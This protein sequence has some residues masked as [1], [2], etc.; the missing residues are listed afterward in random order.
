M[1]Q[2]TIWYD[3]GCP[4][5][6]SE[7]SIM[8]RL[9]RQKAIIFVNIYDDA[10]ICPLDRSLLLTRLHA[11]EDGKILSGAA[12]FAAMWCAIPLLRPLGLLARNPIVL[13]GLERVYL[14]FLR[15]RPRLQRII[16]ANFGA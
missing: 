9:D 10:I 16:K 2:T 15:F 13:N 4:L 5:C 11:F 12:A 3:G 8:R 7:I 6:V 1:D 14:V